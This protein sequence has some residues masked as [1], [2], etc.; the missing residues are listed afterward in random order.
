MADIKTMLAGRNV[1][2]VEDDYLIAEDMT[3]ELEA[4]GA[5]VIGPAASVAAA[6]E[7]IGQTELIDGAIVDINLQG[8]M[9]WPVADAL[10]R[11]EVSFVF[12]TGYDSNF[13]PNCYVEIVR[14]EKPTLLD[15]AAKALFGYRDKA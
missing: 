3:F 6:I 5:K 11:R 9:S 4:G 2:L 13:I 7:L 14:C 12:T 10:L 8:I 15:K 1:L